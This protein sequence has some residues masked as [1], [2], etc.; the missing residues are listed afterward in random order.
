MRATVAASSDWMRATMRSTVRSKSARSIIP[1]WEWVERAG[2]GDVVGDAD[3]QAE[4]DIGIDDARGGSRTTHL[5]AAFF[6]DGADIEDL[7]G[8]RR[9]GE[10]AHDFEHDG[11]ADAVIPGF[12]KIAVVGEN[13]EIGDGCDG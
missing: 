8:M 4:A 10:A 3:L 1:L 6:L 9:L 2:P 13:G 11:A 12:R 5:D 7:V